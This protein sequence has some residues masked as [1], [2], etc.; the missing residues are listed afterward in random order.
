M[1]PK[2]KERK[3]GKRWK[4]VILV[5]V[6]STSNV[7][8]RLFHKHISLLSPVITTTTTP[9]TTTTIATTTYGHHTTSSSSSSFFRLDRPR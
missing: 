7:G 1:V 6:F 3:G 9:P 4:R 2:G 8:R 5:V